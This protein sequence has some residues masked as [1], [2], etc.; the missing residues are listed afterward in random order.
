M[1]IGILPGLGGT[2]GLALLLPFVF[3]MEPSK[4]LAMMIGLQSVTATSDTFPA[5]LM[6]IPGTASAQATV[7]DGFPLSKKGQAARALA[8]GFSASLLGGLF[9]ALVL[10]FAIFYAEP[11]MN[12]MG[13]SEQMMLI[14]LALTTVGML[15][16]SHPLKG[17]AACTIGLMIG[18]FGSAP[19]S[20]VER[21]TFGTE[22]LVDP[23]KLVI[24]G[25]AMFAMPEIVDLLRRQV[26]I[27]ESGALGVGWLQGVKDTLSHW[28]IV[29]RCA[30][31]GCLDR[32]ASRPRRLGHRLDR[33]WPRRADQQGSREL[34]HR[35]HSR[36]DR[37]GGGE[38]R[39]G[40]RRPDPDHPVRHSRL[41]QHGAA[42]RRLC[43]DRHRSGHR[44]DHEPRGSG[45]S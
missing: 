12:A 31:I 40:R 28:W 44:H 25:L 5:I 15:T 39:Q 17:L 30:C 13:F 4:A 20:G 10:S 22:Y 3:N 7:M 23:I 24:V 16:G 1:V 37:A 45:L 41:R 9:G 18:A 11:I 19:V 34:R 42:A 8:A 29:L 43:P 6:G 36:R 14:V 21:L 33:L 35:R 32:R 27:S 26:T 38:Q 2:S